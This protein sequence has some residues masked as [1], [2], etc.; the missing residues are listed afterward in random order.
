ML[1]MIRLVR[2]LRIV[3]AFRKSKD[4]DFVAER[5]VRIA[6]S[7]KANPKKNPAPSKKSKSSKISVTNKQSL[8]LPNSFRDSHRP[9]EREQA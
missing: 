3:K 5:R 7:K 8:S 9:R 6:N 2:L 1:R 4:V